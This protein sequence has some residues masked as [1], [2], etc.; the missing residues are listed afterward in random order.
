VI[1]DLVEAARRFG[2]SPFV[3]ALVFAALLA[4]GVLLAQSLAGRFGDRD[5]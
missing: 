4:A 5:S 3:L 2:T 1:P